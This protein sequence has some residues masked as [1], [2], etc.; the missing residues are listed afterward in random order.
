MG[1]NIN[2]IKKVG[3]TL[4]VFTFGL[5][6]ALAADGYNSNELNSSTSKVE[7]DAM[8][9]ETAVIHPNPWSIQPRLA[10]IHPNPWSIGMETE[11]AVIH[12]SP[13]SKA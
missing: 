2:M 9:F 8:S 13:W 5:V 6:G 7:V 10:V 4:A 12:P 3:L 1:A 11:M